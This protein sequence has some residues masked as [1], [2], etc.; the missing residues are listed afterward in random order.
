MMSR[1]VLRSV[2]IA[3][4]PFIEVGA[5]DA[6]LRF[7]VAMTAILSRP[8][9]SAHVTDGLLLVLRCRKRSSSAYSLVWARWRQRCAAHAL[10]VFGTGSKLGKNFFM[11]DAFA[12]GKRCPGCLDLACFFCALR[13]IV[14]K[15]ARKGSREIEPARQLSAPPN[16]HVIGA[17]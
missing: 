10:E 3:D 11:R 16:R 6:F 7:A 14:I 4:L 5:A 15:S 9:R 12:T 13:L 1:I 8:G 17:R 2:S